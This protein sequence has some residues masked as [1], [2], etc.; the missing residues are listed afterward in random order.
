MGTGKHREGD[1]DTPPPTT[2]CLGPVS[3][4]SC[5]PFS[6]N[7]GDSVTAPAPVGGG[8]SPR[9]VSP[10]GEG[11][12]ARLVLSVPVPHSSLFPF[13]FLECLTLAAAAG[14]QPRHLTSGAASPA[15]SRTPTLR[16][17]VCS[18]PMPPPPRFPALPKAQSPQ[19]AGGGGRSGAASLSSASSYFR[20]QRTP[21]WGAGTSFRAGRIGMPRPSELAS[22]RVRPCTQLPGHPRSASCPSPQVGRGPNSPSQD[23]WSES[24]SARSPRRR[25]PPPAP[26]VPQKPRHQGPPCGRGSRGCLPQFHQQLGGPPPRGATPSS[27]SLSSRPGSPAFH[28]PGS[29]CSLLEAGAPRLFPSSARVGT[30][31][32]CPLGPWSPASGGE[33]DLMALVRSL[34]R[35]VPKKHD[36]GQR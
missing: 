5:S 27:A 31:R 18:P 3:W 7:A 9:S 20:Q 29:P 24:R 22:R 34:Q 4:L 6:K 36:C 23:P 8:I 11:G 10:G 28:G 33:S 12:L 35:S 2:A 30:C 15:P 1:L 25:V 14:R 16:P 21:V 19:G 17:R 26:T 32:C 13:L